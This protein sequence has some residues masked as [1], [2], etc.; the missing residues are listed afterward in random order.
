M[1]IQFEK[2]GLFPVWAGNLLLIFVGRGYDRADAPIR[3]HSWVVCI[4]LGFHSSFSMAVALAG[5]RAHEP[6]LQYG[7][8]IND[9]FS[10]L[11]L[12]KYF[13]PLQW[14]VD[15]FVQF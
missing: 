14:F 7:T 2:A 13:T 10:N 12:I 1:G 8:N 15:F 11:H 9:H 5:R 3:L 6:A 4:N